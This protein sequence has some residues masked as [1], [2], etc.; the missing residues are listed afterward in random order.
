MTER[1]QGQS[2]ATIDKERRIGAALSVGMRIASSRFAGRGFR[3]WHFDANAGSGWNEAVN[4]PG[5][6][7]VFWDVAKLCLSGLE[8]AAFFC[9]VDL[10]AMRRLQLRF[11]GNP[12]AERHS[13]LLPGDNQARWQHPWGNLR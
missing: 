13:F 2:L 1:R 6:P 9:D 3:Y 12:D 4:V 5:S 7:I 10:G 11:N 8:P